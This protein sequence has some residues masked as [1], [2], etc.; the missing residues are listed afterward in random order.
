[1][2]GYLPTNKA[3]DYHCYEA[4]SGIFVR[5]TGDEVAQLLVDMLQ[6]LR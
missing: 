2:Y 1:M 6:Q 5:G 3:F 4:Y